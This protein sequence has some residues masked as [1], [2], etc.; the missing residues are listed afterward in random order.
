MTDV[1]TLP[2]LGETMEE[3]RVVAWL[4][5]AGS[6]F[7]RGDA[8][9][10]IETD[11]T[12]VEVPALVDGRL[13]EILA[14]EGATVRIGDPIARLAEAAAHLPAAAP[15]ATVS[16]DA[17]GGSGGARA[18]DAP[19]AP[20]TRDPAA[21]AIDAGARAT[22]DTAALPMALS[23]PVAERPRA[24]PPARRLARE[25]GI[26]LAHIPGS[27][28]RGRIER[29]DVNRALADPRTTEP[30][31][32]PAPAHRLSGPRTGSPVALLHGLAGDHA[33]WSGL[34]N[35]LAHASRRVLAVDLPGHGAATAEATTPEDLAVGLADLLEE[36]FGGPAHLVAHSLGAV[37]ACALAE[38]GHAR[39][40]TLIA[41]VGIGLSID[42]A[43][44]RGLAGPRSAGEVAHLLDRMCA[45]AMPLSS[46]AVDAIAA[47][48]ARGRL[49]A[50]A[51]TLLGATGQAVS[52]RA[53]LAQLAETLPV[54]IVAP[55]RDRIVDWQDAMTVSP[56]V[57]VHHLPVAGHVAWWDAHADVLAI[58]A[59]AT[60][61]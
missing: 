31:G 37:P 1:L 26:D 46:A 20:A 50:L 44:V 52:L 40:L 25:A 57:A 22:G 3:G 55:H 24:T 36:S 59:R 38:A 35:G 6:T 29:A 13:G 49:F 53:K 42:A 2:R 32:A 45:G 14:P 17:P 60:E 30:A 5:P 47:D 34:G 10:E 54:R 9:V 27:G 15:Q 41:P 11:K 4:L 16:G 23:E 51:D 28:R 7:R 19:L 21:P 8:L 18:P 56:M 61:S 12:V 43:V 33:I 39:S 58:L 48:L